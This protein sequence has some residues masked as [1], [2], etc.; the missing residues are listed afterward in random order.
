MTSTIT[1]VPPTVHYVNVMDFMASLGLQYTRIA[2]TTV[3]FSFGNN[4]V[5]HKPNFL[6]QQPDMVQEKKKDTEKDKKVKFDL[7][8]SDTEPR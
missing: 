4:I 3:I 1:S 2:A 5:I 6:L 7:N 8:H